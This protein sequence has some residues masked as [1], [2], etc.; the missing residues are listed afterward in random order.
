MKKVVK[1]FIAGGFLNEIVE[2]TLY[3][4]L[5]V[6]N[7]LQITDLSIL[8]AEVLLEQTKRIITKFRS[9]YEYL[10]TELFEIAHALVEMKGFSSETLLIN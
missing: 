10:N 8:L 5:F 9:K 1:L 7:T 3:G 6:G 4:N 2:P